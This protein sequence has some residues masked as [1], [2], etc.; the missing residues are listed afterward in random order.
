VLL[1]ELATSNRARLIDARDGSG[2]TD[3][4]TSF[5]AAVRAEIPAS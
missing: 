4:V 2:C 1:V 3:S 5:D